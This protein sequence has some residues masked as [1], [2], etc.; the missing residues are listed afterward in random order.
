[1]ESTSYFD[2]ETPVQLW[3]KRKQEKMKGQEGGERED[4]EQKG[5]G[6]RAEDGE[7]I[8]AF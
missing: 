3:E 6:G 2:L 5:V 8:Q 7:K 4:G 1:M